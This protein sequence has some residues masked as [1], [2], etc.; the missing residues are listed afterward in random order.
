MA[1][2]TSCVSFLKIT[3][4]DA[5]TNLDGLANLTSVGGLLTISNVRVLPHIGCP[6]GLGQLLQRHR[7]QWHR[8]RLG[9]GDPCIGIRPNTGNYHSSHNLKHRYRAVLHALN[10]DRHP[11][12]HYEL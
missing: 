2:L 12:S 5:L 4:N 6:M 11:V 9:G 10:D 7:W 3:Q 1:W 8:V